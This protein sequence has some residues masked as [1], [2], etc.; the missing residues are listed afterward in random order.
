[1]RTRLHLTPEKITANR[2]S[3]VR[4]ATT[5][6]WPYALAPL[7]TIIAFVYLSGWGHRYGLDLKV[8]RDSVKSWVSG[9]DPYLTTFTA[10]KLPFTYPPF[11]LLALLPLSW[12]SFTV[13]QW[14]LWVSSI[15]A[16]TGSVVL[17]L[18]DRG[19]GVTR[20]LWC[21]AITWSCF[22]MVIL[23]PARSGIDYGQIECVLMFLVV[24]DLLL[25]PAPYR[26]ITIGFAA[27]IKLT[28]LVFIIALITMRDL[29]SVTRAALSFLF[30]TALPWLFWP[31]LSRVYWLHDVIS[32]ARVGGITYDG[33]QSWYA[34][35]HRP[36]FSA[37]GS[38]IAWLLLTLLTLAA[39][40]VT[41][42]HCM[43]VGQKTFGIIS[44]A[45]AGLLVSPISWTHHWVWV[46]LIP[47][48]L[49]NQRNVGVPRLVRMLFWGL[50]ALTIAAPYWWFNDNIAADV[51]DAMLPLCA[52]AIL[53]VWAAVAFAHSRDD[54]EPKAVD[55]SN[56]PRLGIRI[57]GRSRL[58]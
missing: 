56:R 2:T 13:S 8:Y 7:A 58:S 22:L 42:W 38:P 36:P 6:H 43:K 50:I 21:E 35:L 29:K 15:A 1:M 17:F 30:L 24:A 28:P 51:C 3:A 55:S 34:V 12:V 5:T 26:G 27:A 45:L 47:P 41:A 48:I 44:I 25:I 37:D 40:T 52:F 4:K 31:A 49:A 39:A 53:A 10:H 20:R 33:N 11:A 14:L 19:V 9:R 57:S 54:L 16:A 46:L 23:E 32:P 18:R